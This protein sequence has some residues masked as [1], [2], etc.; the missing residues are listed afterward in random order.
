MKNLL[1][2]LLILNFASAIGQAYFQH[3]F[4]KFPSQY[5]TKVEMDSNGNYYALGYH[6]GDGNSFH[7]GP[8]LMKF[9]STGNQ[10]WTRY[11]IYPIAGET[12]WI[13]NIRINSNDIEVLKSFTVCCDCGQG[14][15]VL[16]MH[17]SFATGNMTSVDTV[18]FSNEGYN[19]IG[20]SGDNFIAV[21]TNDTIFMF[22]TALSQIGQWHY[23]LPYNFDQSA[24]FVGNDLMANLGYD[25]VVRFY[26][27]DS[28][29]NVE[30]FN[31]KGY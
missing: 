19:P 13:S 31:G 18:Y 5:F 10:V 25:N 4:R 8:F 7:S 20:I 30:I 27:I 16:R 15:G 23:S 24:F 14:T 22:D 12:E 9:D 28:L 17:L 6:T 11:D 2:S 3:N 21:N 26:K 29:S 1:C